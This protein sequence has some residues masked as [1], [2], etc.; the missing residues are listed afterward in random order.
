MNVSVGSILTG[1]PAVLAA[2]VTSLMLSA[3]GLA[4]QAR[5]LAVVI[6]GFAILGILF[7]DTATLRHFGMVIVTVVAV[8]M[9]TV[10][11]LLGRGSVERFVEAL[12]KRPPAS[13]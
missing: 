3:L 8:V 5:G 6:L 12:L 4:N 10:D 2:V 9:G 13:L 7:P 1:D 11:L